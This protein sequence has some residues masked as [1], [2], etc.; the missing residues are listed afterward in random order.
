MWSL[1]RRRDGQAPADLDQQLV[2][3]GVARGVVDVFEAV[4]IEEQQQRH[5]SVC[6]SRAISCS[7]CG[8]EPGA[9]VEFGQRVVTGLPAQFFFEHAARGDVAER[10]DRTFAASVHLH[11]IDRALHRHRP[12]RARVQNTVCQPGTWLPCA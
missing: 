1:A 6:F 12:S 11:R 4:Q 8:F 9:V 10:H 5:L 7:S 2:A 3:G